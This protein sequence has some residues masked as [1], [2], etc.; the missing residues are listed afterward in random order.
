MYTYIKERLSRDGAEAVASSESTQQTYVVVVHKNRYLAI[1]QLSKNQ[2]KLFNKIMRTKRNEGGK[3]DNKNCISSRNEERA[4]DVCKNDRSS[5]SE[6][7]SRFF[8]RRSEDSAS[9]LACLKIISSDNFS[10]KEK[11]KLITYIYIYRDD[12]TKNTCKKKEKKGKKK[13]KKEKKKKKVTEKYGGS[14]RLPIVARAWNFFAR[15]TLLCARAHRYTRSS[16]YS[17]WQ[18]VVVPCENNFV[19]VRSSAKS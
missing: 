13:E 3:N 4:C 11:Y 14:K 2:I 6:G 8:A 17:A 19:L 1:L 7:A 18:L 5:G 12:R 15:L 9:D 10:K 16:R